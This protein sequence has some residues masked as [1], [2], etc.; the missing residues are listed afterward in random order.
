MKTTLLWAGVGVFTAGYVAGVIKQR[1]K[2]SRE[3]IAAGS[4]GSAFAMKV[5]SMKPRLAT[6]TQGHIRDLQ[7]IFA[8]DEPLNAGAQLATSGM[9][10]Y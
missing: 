8:L 6:G 7:M 1:M 3:I 9:W 5:A 4:E 2:T 10:R